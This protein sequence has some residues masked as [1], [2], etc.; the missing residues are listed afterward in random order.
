MDEFSEEHP[1][2]HTAPHLSANN[3]LYDVG[4]NKFVKKIY[5]KVTSANDSVDAPEM[6]EY[7]EFVA[8][9]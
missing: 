6:D 1:I 2:N 4:V 5:E 7:D 9:S 8:A 3:V